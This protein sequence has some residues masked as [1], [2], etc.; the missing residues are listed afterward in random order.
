MS[1]INRAF[2]KLKEKQ[3][4]WGDVR[5]LNTCVAGK[6]YGKMTVGKAFK[7]LVS[8]DDYDT[9]DFNELLDFAYSL[10]CEKHKK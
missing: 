9:E 1:K 8:R 6:H 4:D 5:I 3:T 7:T 10:T 2:L